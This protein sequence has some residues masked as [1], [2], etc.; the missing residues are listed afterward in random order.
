MRYAF[1][2]RGKATGHDL[3]LARLDS[4][5]PRL[6]RKS[7]GYFEQLAWSPDGTT[8]LAIETVQSKYSGMILERKYWLFNAERLTNTLIGVRSQT[9]THAI[10]SSDGKFILFLGME[11]QDGQENL[12][13]QGLE[14]ARR[15]IVY[16]QV[17][18]IPWD[19]SYTFLERVATLP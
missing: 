18:P 5:R 9:A 8:L 2:T 14:V 7:R 17:V 15:R 4:A 11:E 12:R 19:Q 6:I 3:Y 1:T 16:D 10:W 13:L